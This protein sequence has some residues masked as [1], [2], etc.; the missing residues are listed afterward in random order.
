MAAPRR[1][2]GCSEELAT[3]TFYQ[4]DP[5]H[6]LYLKSIGIRLD[7]LYISLLNF[8][9][10]FGENTLPNVVAEVDFLPGLT[11]LGFLCPQLVARSQLVVG[12]I[13]VVNVLVVATDPGEVGL[14][15]REELV[16]DLTTAVLDQ[17][18]GLFVADDDQYV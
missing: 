10:V 3:R 14:V 13:V 2:R 15:E 1:L 5:L 12:C 6:F 16:V 17:F 8:Q 7:K 4:F 11:V 9:R 18:V